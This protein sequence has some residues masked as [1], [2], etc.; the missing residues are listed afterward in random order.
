MSEN[1]SIL[2][3]L[4]ELLEKILP[5]INFSQYETIPKYD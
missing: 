3:S 1:D 4:Q 2:V 5:H